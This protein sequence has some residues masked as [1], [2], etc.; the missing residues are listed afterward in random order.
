M[1]KIVGMMLSLFLLAGVCSASS[2]QDLRW[3]NKKIAK[4]IQIVKECEKKLQEY[5]N[6]DKEIYEQMAKERGWSQEKLQRKLNA[7]MRKCIKYSGVEQ[8]KGRLN[9]LIADREFLL[10]ELW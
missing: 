9:S 3:L 1:K 7:E 4:Y 2:V 10:E 5:I 8:A 6:N